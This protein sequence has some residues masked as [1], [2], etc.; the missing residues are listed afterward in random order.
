MHLKL[1]LWMV[2]VL[3]ECL[4]CNSQTLPSLGGNWLSFGSFC[5]CQR[6]PWQEPYALP[7]KGWG[8]SWLLLLNISGGDVGP[9]SVYVACKI[10]RKTLR[11]PG[12]EPE[13]LIFR[14]IRSI[15]SFLS[16]CLLIFCQVHIEHCQ[17]ME[18]RQGVQTLGPCGF[19]SSFIL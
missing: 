19:S 18:C 15:P 7:G 4:D 16:P 9:N 13:R 14:V 10:S 1:F 5:L 12:L 3:S 6:S 11:G 2:G 17:E 8:H